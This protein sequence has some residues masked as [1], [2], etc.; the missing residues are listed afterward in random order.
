M[1]KRLTI[2]DIAKAVGV[3]PMTVSAA[4][5]KTQSTTR[6]SADTAARVRKVAEKMNFR[7]SL[8][9]RQL[10]NSENH[11]IGLIVETLT[12]AHG[13]LVK[14]ASIVS[15]HTYLADRGWHLQILQENSFDWNAHN[16]PEYIRTFN[17]AAFV[18]YSKSPEAD[19][20]VINRL[21]IF[22]IPWVLLDGP[23]G[24]PNTVAHDNHKAAQI[25]TEHLLELG[26]RRIF[27]YAFTTDHHSN[28]ERQAG[29]EAAMRAKGYSSTIVTHPSVSLLLSQIEYRDFLLA[30]VRAHQP[31][32]IVCYNDILAW[33]VN[34]VLQEAGFRVPG[35]ISL[36][37]IS[38]IHGTNHCAPAL[39]SASLG[40][41]KMG[42]M[43]GGMLLERVARPERNV[44][45]TGH[46]PTL[47]LRRSTARP[48]AQSAS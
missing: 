19:E 23:Q 3:S 21:N 29:Y 18:L 47:A 48:A 33:E 4:L 6:V 32:A 10:R 22:Q 30:A 16:Y 40:Y 36:V 7:L 2:R 27:Y 17:H 25:V 9:G 12:P 11:N 8:N 13:M 24:R 14:M 39:T 46:E 1:K 26:H 34:Q 31:T 41:A 45:G 35:E 15:L 42:Q 20:R 43:V 28:R 44:P 5:S 38:D 37:G